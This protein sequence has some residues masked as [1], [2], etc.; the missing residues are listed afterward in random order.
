MKKPGGYLL[1]GLQKSRHFS[2]RYYLSFVAHL[3][4]IVV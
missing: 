3:D 2:G 1:N 4:S